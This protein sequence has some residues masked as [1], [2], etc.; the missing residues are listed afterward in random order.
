MRA[1]VNC[2]RKKGSRVRRIGSGRRHRQRCP[3]ACPADGTDIFIS[4]R[5][6]RRGDGGR[7]IARFRLFERARRAADMRLTC[8]PSLSLILF[9]G[10]DISNEHNEMTR[11]NVRGSAFPRGTE[12]PGRGEEKKKMRGKVPRSSGKDFLG[13]R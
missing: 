6:H 1:E 3:A 11:R 7:E 12:F 5:S 9:I 13:M 4:V 8:V 10:V 2:F